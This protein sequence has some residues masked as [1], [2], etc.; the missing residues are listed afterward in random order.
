[1]DFYLILHACEYSGRVATPL[2]DDATI[3]RFDPV[4]FVLVKKPD[5]V[6]ILFEYL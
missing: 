4:F 5:Q 6:D 2:K 1:V 3:F